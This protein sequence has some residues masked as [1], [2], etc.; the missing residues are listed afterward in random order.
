MST[1]A[2]TGSLS[3][4]LSVVARRAGEFLL[5]P[6]AEVVAHG[7]APGVV[8]VVALAPGCGTTTVA[9]AIASTLGVPVAVWTDAGG[10]ELAERC[11][12]GGPLVLEVPHGESAGRAAS[13]ADHV[14]VVAGPGVE[15]SLASSVARSLEAVGPRPAIV[16]NRAGDDDRWDGSLDVA[17]PVA[18]WA[19]RLAGR[20][21][22]VT[23][24]LRQAISRLLEIAASPSL[25]YVERSPIERGKGRA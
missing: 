24:D 15:P 7:E 18:P 8:A 13:L 23:G 6:P 11:G 12:A 25:N 5:E 20:G 3:R 16:V 19:A 22:P 9:R 4:G 14:I 10:S 21:G 2:H 17:L 1:A